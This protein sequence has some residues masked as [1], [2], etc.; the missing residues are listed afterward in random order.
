MFP[1]SNSIWRIFIVKLSMTTL[2]ERQSRHIV[3]LAL[4]NFVGE[5]CTGFSYVH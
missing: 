4:I 3:S 2:G 1:S 5:Q